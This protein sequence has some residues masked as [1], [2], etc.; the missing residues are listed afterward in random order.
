MIDIQVIEIRDLL[1]IMAVR[2]VPLSDPPALDIRG[3]DF[4]HVDYVLINDVASPSIVVA[5]ST[6]LVAQLPATEEVAMIRSIVAV[7]NRLTRT[8]RSKINFRVNDTPSLVDGMERLVQTFLKVL[9]QTPG[10]DIFSPKGGGG[11]LAALG[12]QIGKPSSSTIV[13]DV[14]LGVTRTRQ[15]MMQL[16][17][18]ESALALD[19][20]L[21]YARVLE[22]KFVANELSLNTKIQI[23][24]QAG[25]ATTLG[26][27]L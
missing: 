26:L 12:K 27:G 19:E 18:K 15:Q 4:N 7:S 25:K 22:A 13:S 2:P 9:L 10:S 24:N 23:G 5:S 11:L 8:N 20:R 16:Q 17:T 1:K 6:Q 21:L 3:Q 14:H